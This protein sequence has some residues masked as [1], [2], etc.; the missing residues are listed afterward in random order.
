MKLAWGPIHNKDALWVKVMKAKYGYGNGKIPKVHKKKT[1]SS[2]AWKEITSI[3]DKFY[4]QLIWK[5]GYGNDI[6]FWEDH[7]VLGIHKLRED[8][9]INLDENKMVEKVRDY[10]N[11]HGNWDWGKISRVL[12]DELI[13]HLQTLK[14]PKISIGED[15]V[16]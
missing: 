3:W 16:S 15:C 10:A 12:P 1:S 9:N 11:E 2:N 8:A 14:A 13:D 5:I 4:N 7:W 6:L